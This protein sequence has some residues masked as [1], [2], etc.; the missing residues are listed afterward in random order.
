MYLQCIDNSGATKSTILASKSRVSPIRVISIPRLELCACVLLA[1]LVKKARSSLRLKID[2]VVLHTDSTIAL[3]WLDT[4]ANHLKTF[5][6][7]RVSKVQQ[8]TEDCRWRHVPS[9]LYPADIISRGLG[10]GDLPYS[11][12]WWNGPL[13]CGQEDTPDVPRR[14]TEMKDSEYLCEL[15]LEKV[16]TSSVCMSVINDFLADLLARTGGYLRMLR[17][18]AF[19]LRFVNNIKKM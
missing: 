4:P 12:L 1:Q 9:A 14:P 15:K 11:K 10:P 8:L 7:N 17:V 18:I 2:D 6:A 5:I 19:V 3:A 16:P 13:L